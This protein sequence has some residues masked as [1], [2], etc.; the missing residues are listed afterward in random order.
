MVGKTQRKLASHSL[1]GIGSVVSVAVIVLI[2]FVSFTA[3]A[4]QEQSQVI[5]ASK[6]MDHPIINTKGEQILEIDDLILRRNGNVKRVILSC[7]GFLGLG[8][9]RVAVPFRN[10]KIEDDKI[11]Y[12]ITEEE[13]KQMA[14]FNYAEDDLYTGYY[15]EMQGRQTPRTPGAPYRPYYGP[16]YPGYGAW[17]QEYCRGAPSYSPGSILGSVVLSH[18]VINPQCQRLGVVDDLMIDLDGQVKEIVLSDLPP[19]LNKTRVSVPYK[20]FQVTYW[21]LVYDVTLDELSNLPEFHYNQ[22]R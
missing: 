18:P 2:C 8:A 9:K 14:D 22:S 17:S 4:E 7:C 3:A 13:Y 10:L 19:K 11:I 15:S 6:L 1:C 16:H 5:R 12:D 21:G 20:P